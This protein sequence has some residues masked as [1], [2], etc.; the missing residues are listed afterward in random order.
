MTVT[1]LII[2]LLCDICL[3][4]IL[5][6]ELLK[7]VSREGEYANW[8]IKVHC[9]EVEGSRRNELLVTDSK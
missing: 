8:I 7:F 2:L 9:N 4:D 3:Q 5:T 6:T 1:W